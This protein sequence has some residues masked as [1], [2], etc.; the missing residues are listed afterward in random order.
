MNAPDGYRHDRYE[1]ALGTGPEAW[2]KAVEGI[3]RWAAHSGAGASVFPSDA[4]LVEG[5]TLLVVLSKGPISVVAPCRIVYVV[6]EPTRFGFGYGTLPGHPEQGEEVFVV[7]AAVDGA[8]TFKVTAFSRPRE[9]VAKVGGPASRP[10]Q[11]R[12]T[13]RYL[14]GLRRSTARTLSRS[15][16]RRTAATCSI[17]PTNRLV[18]R[19]SDSPDRPLPVLLRWRLLVGGVPPQRTG[20]SRCV[21]RSTGPEVFF[22]CLIAPRVP[23]RVV[24]GPS[25]CPYGLVARPGPA[26]GEWPPAV[27]YRCGSGRGPVGRLRPRA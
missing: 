11:R 14:V 27:P 12:V 6:D 21:D 7:E 1:L 24:L 15:R 20:P 9:L 23:P 3:T 22:A 13:E 25:S 19:P 17:G 16:S 2:E 5:E 10:I 4:R 18:P 8:V 26:P